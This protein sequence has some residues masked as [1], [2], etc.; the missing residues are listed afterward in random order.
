MT[1]VDMSLE[2]RL[3]R[4]RVMVEIRQRGASWA[5]VGQAY[6]VSKQR[7]MQIVNGQEPFGEPGQNKRWAK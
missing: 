2:E 6:G 4:Y 3:A 1:H 5:A 7:A